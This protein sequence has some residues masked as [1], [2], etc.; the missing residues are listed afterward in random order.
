METKAGKAL[1]GKLVPL[2]RR[3]EVITNK[4]HAP[5]GQ[6]VLWVVRL[7]GVEGGGGGNLRTLKC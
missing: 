4:Q 6:I 7:R 2:S 1:A 3:R 5:R